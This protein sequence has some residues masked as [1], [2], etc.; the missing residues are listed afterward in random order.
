MAVIRQ[1]R[2]VLGRKEDNTFIL[3][4]KGRIIP[5]DP[6]RI[7]RINRELREK[8]EIQKQLDAEAEIWAKNH[9]CI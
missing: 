6:K 9:G 5:S 3:L 4:T 7:A 8:V 1:R 2:K